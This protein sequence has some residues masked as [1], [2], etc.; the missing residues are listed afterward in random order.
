M[1]KLSEY[2][3]MLA[4]SGLWTKDNSDSADFHAEIRDV[5]YNSLKARQGTLFI[6]KGEI[7]RAHV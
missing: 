5:S 2:L 7:G 4:E 3:N 1:K 6:Y